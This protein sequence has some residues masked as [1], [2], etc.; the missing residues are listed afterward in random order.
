MTDVTDLADATRYYPILLEATETRIVWVDAEDPE[1][2][3][4]QVEDCAY[5]YWRDGEDDADSSGVTA[6]TAPSCDS[7][8][9]RP[10]GPHDACR[11]CGAV[12]TSAEPDP[13]FQHPG[14][15]SRHIHDV[16]VGTVRMH[17]DQGEQWRLRCSCGVLLQVLGDS[18]GDP[19][20]AAAAVDHVA[21]H[22][23]YGNVRLGLVSDL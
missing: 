22:R 7:S 1:E 2:A 9:R 8:W 21:G 23:H 6:S 12:A 15:C 18:P 10:G 4:R 16:H 11:E 5:D 20:L 13:Y 3:L 19:V 17:P 14:T